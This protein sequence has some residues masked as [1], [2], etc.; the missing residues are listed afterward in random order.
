M[1]IKLGGLAVITGAVLFSLALPAHGQNP[2]TATVNFTGITNGNIFGDGYVDPYAGTVK[3]N[4]VQVNPNGLIV[5][6]DYNDNIYLPSETWNATAIQASTLG[7]TTPITDALFGGA[8][9]GY[10]NIGVNGYAAV[11]SLVSQLLSL[12]SS[13]PAQ[14][15]TQGYLSGAIWYITS[16]GSIPFSYLNPIEQNF[17]TVAEAPFGGSSG[18]GQSSSAAISALGADTTLWVLTPI[19]GTQ[20]TGGRPQEMWTDPMS[21]PEGGAALLYLLL[22]GGVCFGA[23]F[24]SRRNRFANL[25]SA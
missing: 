17:V 3:I 19:L 7:T 9:L 21:V 20:S 10:A 14:A 23:M 22:A 16:N 24:L 8:T 11:A 13:V 15:V 25:A 1:K 18:I 2:P 5:C 4:G 12:N 6:D